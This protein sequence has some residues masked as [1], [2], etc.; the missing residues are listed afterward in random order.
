MALTADHTKYVLA[1]DR[2]LYLAGIY[3]RKRNEY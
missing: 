2:R 1:N 3:K